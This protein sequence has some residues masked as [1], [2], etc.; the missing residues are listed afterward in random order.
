MAPYVSDAQRRFFHSPGAKRAGISKA[1]VKEFDQASKGRKLPARVKKKKAKIVINNKL[2]GDYGAMNPKTNK[3][4]INVRAHK[5][6]KAE[7]AS[8]IRHELLHV[9]HPRMTEKDV[10]KKSAK[11]KIPIAEQHKLI[12]KLRHKKIHYKQGAL[13]R[14]FKIKRGDSMEPGDFIRKSNELSR[15]QVAIRGMI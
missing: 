15:K 13:K 14:K 8:T 1:T 5:G 9:K 6:D 10:Y 12:A 11:T 4:E 2:R 3:V 7:L